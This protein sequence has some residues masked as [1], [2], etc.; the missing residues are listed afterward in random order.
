MSRPSVWPDV[1]SARD[2]FVEPDDG[3]RD[4]H[5]VVVRPPVDAVPSAE[6]LA[7]VAADHG[8]GLGNEAPDRVLGPWADELD[9]RDAAQRRALLH[10]LAHACFLVPDD[11][12][13]TPFHY[14]SRREPAATVDV[15]ARL[16]AVG[17]APLLPWRWASDG[18]RWR[19][20]AIVPGVADVEVPAAA[21]GAVPGAAA[22]GTLLA[23]VVIT[24]AGPVAVGPI[25]LPGAAPPGAVAVWAARIVD[26][27]RR[28]DPS[29]VAAAV[30][31]HRGHRLA[32][33]AAEWS[34]LARCS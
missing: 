28:D 33:R 8:P 31:R 5:T 12:P 18:D 2:P 6:D 14:F 7:R 4:L 29:A 20:D 24:A 22:G 25:A 21:L 1:L 26:E 32:R 10:A 17:E 11:D 16:R 19:L 3:V 23:R 27:A 13:F 9:V 34:W 15:R 30:W